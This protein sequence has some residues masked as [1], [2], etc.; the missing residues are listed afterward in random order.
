MFYIDILYHSFMIVNKYFLPDTKD[1]NSET[2]KEQS[3]Y[4]KGLT[5]VQPST[6]EREK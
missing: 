1:Y 3:I 6:L 5:D 2:E 4:E